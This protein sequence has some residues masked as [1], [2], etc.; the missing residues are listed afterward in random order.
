MRRCDTSDATRF[1]TATPWP[2]S[3]GSWPSTTRWRSICS[4][5]AIWSTPRGAP[6]F[7]RAA[8]LSPGGLSVV[9]LKSAID[10]GARSR[11]VPSIGPGSIVSIARTD[12]D[13]VVTEH[14]L[15]DLR[16]ADLHERAKALIGIA[17]PAFREELEGAWGMQARLL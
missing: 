1:S 9:A 16:G 17:A 10:G 13:L 2:P 12:V 15:A 5:N 11:I 3:N 14:G 7:A 4:A 8:H 6:D